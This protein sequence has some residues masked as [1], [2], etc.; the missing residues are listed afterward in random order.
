MNQAPGWIFAGLSLLL[1]GCEST[2]EFTAP[3]EPE[4]ILLDEDFTYN[5]GNWFTGTREESYRL[6]FLDGQYRL[7]SWNDTGVVA[8]KSVPIPEDGNFDIKVELT[9]RQA[10]DDFGYGFCWGGRDAD[11]RF[12]FFISGDGEYSVF[13][14]VGGEVREFS[15]WTKS[16]SLTPKKNTLEIRRRAEALTCF[17]NGQQAVRLS[18]APFA[19]SL[20]GFAGD[21]KIDFSVDRLLI[22]T[23]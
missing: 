20:V 15:P 19:G 4:R 16:A 21:G 11:N 7:Q 18:H 22:L 17:I 2:M 8:V 3:A 9:L 5:N 23:E 13:Q 14:R 6:E 10:G 1:W 12:C